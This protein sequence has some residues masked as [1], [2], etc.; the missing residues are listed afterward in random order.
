MRKSGLVV[1]VA[2]LALFSCKENSKKEKFRPPSTGAVNSVMIVMEN[3]LW[4]GAVGDKVRELFAASVLAVPQTEPIF[5]LTQIPKQVFTGGV[6]NSRSVLYVELD[7]LSLSHI[8]TDVYASPQKVAVVKGTNYEEL[9]AN[10]NNLAPNAIEVF[11]NNE[12]NEAQRRFKR[13]LNKEPD[14]KEEFGITLEI[15]TA[16][17]V[18]KHEANFVWIDRQIPKGNMNIVA[19]AMPWNSF[20]TDSTFIK[21]IIRMRDSIGKKYIPGPDVK[22]GSTHMITERAFAPY[23]FP[24]EIDEK[25]AVEVRGIWE[26]NGYPMAGPFLSYIINDEANQRKLILEGFIFAPSANKR[27]DLLELEAIMKTVQFME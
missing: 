7:S 4:Q 15:P 22:T 20:S 1:L 17:R 6:T 23:V 19:Y 12:I 3:E 24:A 16:Y 8:K 2:F 21:E 25:K 27:D 14:L 5:S 26:M 13:S 18:G 11:R 10:L 9:I